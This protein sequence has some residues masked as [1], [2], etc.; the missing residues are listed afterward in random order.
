MLQ[1]SPAP[2]DQIAGLKAFSQCLRLVASAGKARPWLAP[3]VG[4]LGGPHEVARADQPLQGPGRVV[5]PVGG[6][7]KITARCQDAGERRDAV[8][9]DEAALPVAGLR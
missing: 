6:E 3:I 8:G 2:E 9:L 1:P 5:G 7:A 4:T